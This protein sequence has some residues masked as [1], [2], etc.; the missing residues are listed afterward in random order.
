MPADLHVH[1]TASDGTVTPAGV[2]QL[3]RALGLGAIA[4]T[5]HDTVSGV[6]PALQRAGAPGGPR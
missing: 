4:I 5:D 6:A 2:V 3:A 1:T